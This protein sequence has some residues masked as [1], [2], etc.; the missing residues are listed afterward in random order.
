MSETR[1]GRDA[2]SRQMELLLR[3]T[4]NMSDAEKQKI[5][6]QVSAVT[7]DLRRTIEMKSVEIPSGSRFRSKSREVK[8]P[9]LRRDTKLRQDTL[10][11]LV[12]LEQK[13]LEVQT[14]SKESE[15]LVK[16]DVTT[17]LTQAKVYTEE[18]IQGVRKLVQVKASAFLKLTSRSRDG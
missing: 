3:E 10:G 11:R 6:M 14:A 7:Q 15:R 9:F 16:E 5:L 2:Q 13:L 4:S 1:R 8:I 12:A 17:K 18:G